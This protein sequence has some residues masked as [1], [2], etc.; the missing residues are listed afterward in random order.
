MDYRYPPSPAFLQCTPSSKPCIVRYYAREEASRHEQNQHNSYPHRSYVAI[1]TFEKHYGNSCVGLGKD[2]QKKWELKWD[3]HDKEKQFRSIASLPLAHCIRRKQLENKKGYTYKNKESFLENKQTTV[4]PIWGAKRMP[5]A[6]SNVDLEFLN[7]TRKVC[8]C[9][10]WPQIALA[11]ATPPSNDSWWI[12]KLLH[13]IF[14]CSR[15]KSAHLELCSICGKIPMSPVLWP[16]HQND[17][18]V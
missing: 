11:L 1:L 5:V 18:W 2:P 13:W 17:T 3:F 9:T 14:S 12:N 7:D 10:F 4:L 16:Y 8:S 15:C 6:E